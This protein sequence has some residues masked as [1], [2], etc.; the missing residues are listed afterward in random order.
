[1]GRARARRCRAL[2]AGARD[3]LRLEAGFPLYGH[4]LTEATNPLC[5]DFAWV[6][7]DKEF[8]GRGAMWGA[9]CERRLV[10]MRMVTVPSH[11]RGTGSWTATATSWARS[12]PVRCHR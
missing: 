11:A 12:P 8:H 4:E 9:Q 7:K 6:V 5:T 1:M 10:G 3:T 2:R